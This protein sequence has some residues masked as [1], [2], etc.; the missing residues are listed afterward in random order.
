MASGWEYEGLV[1]KPQQLQANFDP[2]L[3]KK[4]N[5]NIASLMVCHL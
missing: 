2:G 5:K 1:F 3:P 4:A